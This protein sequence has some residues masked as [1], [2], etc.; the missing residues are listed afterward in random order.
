M[1]INREIKIRFDNYTFEAIRL[2]NRIGQGDPLSMGLYQYYNTD[3]LDIPS[4]PNQ[5]AIAYVNDVII[6]TSGNSFKETH[7]L[8][9]DMMSKDSGTTNWLKDHNSPLKYS[10]LALIDFSHQNC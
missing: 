6:Y 1:L 5:L 4:E 9:A 8:I 10:K 7:E 3:L 2:N